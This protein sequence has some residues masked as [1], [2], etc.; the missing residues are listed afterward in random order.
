[1]V[2]AQCWRKRL[3]LGAGLL[4]AAACVA[5]PTLTAQDKTEPKKGK[6]DA[7]KSEAPLKQ[8]VFIQ[9]VHV[10]PSGHEQIKYINELL[11]NQWNDNKVVPSE[12]CTDYE[13]IRRASL[14]I[15]GRI[16]KTHEIEK[17]MSWP[18]NKRRSMLIEKLLDS[19]EY[20]TN[21]ANVWTNLMLT[22]Q[23]IPPIYQK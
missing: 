2:R 22:R 14:D 10:G 8:P 15:I 19:T 9:E 1:M 21:W 3:V 12:R 6:T 13:F 7:K 16:A 18:A 23:G 4:I 17:Y 5:A 20:A 11:Q